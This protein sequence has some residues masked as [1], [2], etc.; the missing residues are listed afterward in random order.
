MTEQQARSTQYERARREF[1]SL[2]IEDK[3]IFLVESTVTTVA[4]GIEEVGRVIAD[5]LDAL[6]HPPPADPIDPE[7]PPASEPW[8][9]ARKRR[10]SRTSEPPTE[11][12]G[13]PLSGGP[14]DLPGAEM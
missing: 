12:P 6:F 10:S 13:D 8:P 5:E 11:P 3:A 1:D 4:R 9:R 14:D 2:Q 7:R